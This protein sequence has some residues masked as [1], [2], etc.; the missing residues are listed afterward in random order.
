MN[1]AAALSSSSSSSSSRAVKRRRLGIK[2]APA[3][4]DRCSDTSDSSEEEYEDLADAKNEL[5]KEQQ[6]FQTVK[7][8]LKEEEKRVLKAI[9]SHKNEYVD[10]LVDSRL[11]HSNDC[12]YLS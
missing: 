8:L 2:P 6:G 5:E 11:A 7:N 4:Q 1:A 12:F 9:Q 10:I 3:C